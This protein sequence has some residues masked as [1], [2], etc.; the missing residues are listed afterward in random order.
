ML[1]SLDLSRGP[2]GVSAEPLPEP[3]ERR[4]PWRAAVGA[5]LAQ[6]AGMLAFSVVQY[7]DFSLTFDFGARAQAWAA[8]A[9]GHMN[10]YD[11][12]FRGLFWQNDFEMF[13]WPFAAL[14]H[15]YPHSIDL[16]ILQDLAVFGTEVAV[17]AWAR[18]ILRNGL[19]RRR[20]AD[21]LLLSTAIVLAIEPWAWE[22]IAFDL[23]FEP[24][25]TLFCV[26]AGRDLWR[27]HHKRLFVW[28]PLAAMSG[29]LG[30]TYLVGVGA[31]GAVAGRSTR[32]SGIA[33]A[34]FGLIA[35]LAISGAG[36]GAQGGQLLGRWYGYLSPHSSGPLGVASIVHGL[37]AHPG[38]GLT[39]LG[40]HS[41]AILILLYG[42]GI[43][44]LASW[45]GLLPALA[46]VLPAALNSDDTFVRPVHAFQTWPAVPFLIVGAVMIASSASS[47]SV[48]PHDS[49]D[50][51]WTSGSREARSTSCRRSSRRIRSPSRTSARCR[52]RS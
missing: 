3:P 34:V 19:V 26:L 1:A 46:V 38:L 15:I 48:R 9:H 10:P 49:R 16:L 25:V 41:L 8:I 17:L 5:I 51:R 6:L 33:L 4:W 12:V 21:I 20:I 7:R 2:T 13:T 18:D 23:H 29:L 24:F 35:F 39:M 31:A 44:G 27:G 50:R 47:G 11:T 52:T 40:R 30:G 36:G 22:T 45:W 28:A 32:R 37:L 14:Y 42:C 43:V